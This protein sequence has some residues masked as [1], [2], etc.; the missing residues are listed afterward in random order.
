MH[1]LVRLQESQV[2]KTSNPRR[3]NTLFKSKVFRF[4][5]DSPSP[6]KLVVARHRAKREKVQPIQQ[7][8]FKGR[9]V[10][11]NKKGEAYWQP[12]GPGGKF[13]PRVMISASLAAKLA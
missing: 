12:M 5:E 4:P 1:P 11:V 13:L 8:P 7:I 9:G 6:T 3:G 2:K 10:T